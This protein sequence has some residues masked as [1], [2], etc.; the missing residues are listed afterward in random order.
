[1]LEKQKKGE[2]LGKKNTWMATLFSGVFNK[3]LKRLMGKW[4]V[5]NWKTIGKKKWKGKNTI[6]RPTTGFLKHFMEIQYKT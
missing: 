2:P 1:M 3:S 5:W 6:K 4:E